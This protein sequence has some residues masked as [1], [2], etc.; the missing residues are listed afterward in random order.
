MGKLWPHSGE[1]AKKVFQP[2]EDYKQ[3][4]KVRT[5]NPEYRK[6]LVAKISMSDIKN[7]DVDPT[8]IW[9]DLS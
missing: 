9:K 4:P 6:R 3:A 1:V 5:F 2:P 7:W 8:L